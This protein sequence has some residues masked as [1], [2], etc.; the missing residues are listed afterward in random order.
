MYGPLVLLS[1]VLGSYQNPEKTL[2]TSR[3]VKKKMKLNT[4]NR[5]NFRL[6]KIDKRTDRQAR[7]SKWSTTTHYCEECFYELFDYE[8]EHVCPTLVD[9]M[10]LVNEKTGEFRKTH[11]RMLQI[12]KQRKELKDL[13][14][15]AAKDTR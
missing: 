4:E 13:G 15:G 14:G 3:K 11:P 1:E 9:N 7:K 2:S 10:F 6:D 5:K 12:L 8:T